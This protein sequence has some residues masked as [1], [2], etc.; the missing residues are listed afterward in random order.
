ML[1]PHCLWHGLFVEPSGAPVGAFSGSLQMLNSPLLWAELFLNA[2][3]K[4]RTQ[5]GVSILASPM[6]VSASF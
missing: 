6:T 4:H 3:E 1:Q 2:N 5:S